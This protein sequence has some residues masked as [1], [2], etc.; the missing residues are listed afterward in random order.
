MKTLEVPGLGPVS[1]HKAAQ[2]ELCDEVGFLDTFHLGAAVKG[3][4]SCRVN[5]FSE[6]AIRKAAHSLVETG[7]LENFGPGMYRWVK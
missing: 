2:I 3:I 7:Q 1:I 6:K 4:N 5:E